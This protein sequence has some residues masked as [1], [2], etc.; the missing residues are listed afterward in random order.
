MTRLSTDAVIVALLL[1]DEALT[2]LT[3]LR[4]WAGV[5][6]PPRNANYK[7]SDGEAICLKTVSGIDD[8]TDLMRHD[9]VQFKCYA[10]SRAKA[11]TLAGVLHEALQNKRTATLKWARRTLTPS[12]I[13][14]PETDWPYAFCQYSIMVHQEE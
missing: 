12:I 4:I 9:R 3:A 13:I 10:A 6:Y 11:D 2:N 5:T 7:L 14:E 1:D 8:Y